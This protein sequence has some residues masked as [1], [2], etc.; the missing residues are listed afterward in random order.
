VIFLCGI[1]S[2][3][4]LRLVIEAVN[5]LGAS[6]AVFNQ[7][8]VA[9]M[10][11]EFE[12][13]N[14]RVGGQMYLEGRTYR[15]EQFD[16]IYTRLMDH[17]FLPEIEDEPPDSPLRLHS[18]ALHHALL[19]W[20]EIAPG[21]VLNRMADVGSNL[22]KPYQ[23]QLIREYGFAIPETLVT[24]DPELVRDFRR[25]HGRVIYKSVSYIRSIVQTLEDKDLDRLERVRCC[26]TQ[27]Q[28]FIEGV[29]VRVHT[30]GSQVFATAIHTPVTDYRY[31]YLEG[32]QERLE[33]T[34]LDEEV[35]AKCVALSAALGLHLAGVDLKITPEGRVYCLEVNP[36]PAFGYYELHTGQP[37]ARAVA[38]YL[39]G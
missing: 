26:P 7:R 5:E 36:C 32:Q 12:I 21:R 20:F 6:R 15:L 30:L 24:N 14:G 16:A 17:Q 2:E 13:V 11:L 37:I 29:N 33:A 19:R 34:E 4:S 8:Q 35:A 23:A 1:P 38:G 31:A 25:K 39:A 27:F 10:A 22:S 18:Q 3:P 28:E 9:A